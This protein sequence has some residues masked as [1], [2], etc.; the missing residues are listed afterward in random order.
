MPANVSFTKVILTQAC[1]NGWRQIPGRLPSF[2]SIVTS[3]V[4][5][6]DDLQ[7]DCTAGLV[8]GTVILFDEYFNYPKLGKARVQGLPGI[9]RRTA[10]SN[11]PISRL[12][13]SKSR[14]ELTQSAMDQSRHD[15]ETVSSRRNNRRPPR[16]ACTNRRPSLRPNGRHRSISQSS[17]RAT[18]KQDFIIS[19]I[20]TVRAALAEVG[21]LSYEIIVIDDYFAGSLERDG[22]EL[23]SSTHPTNASCC[24]P[25]RRIAAWRRTILTAPFLG[26]GKYYSLICGDDA[27][28]KE[29]MVAVFRE[30]GRADMIIP[31]YVTSGG[32]EPVSST[33][34]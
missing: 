5:R 6:Q 23:H 26:K 16:H 11:T 27:E 10:R 12:R 25:T 33:A 3:T 30:I 31:Y 15:A 22:S 34:V 24:G 32:K 18:T 19:T 13:G 20:E 17:S 29:T 7:L 9:G 4:R 1:R 14:C 8:P 2:T 21:S 28:P